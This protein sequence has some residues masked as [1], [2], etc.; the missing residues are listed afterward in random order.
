MLEVFGKGL[1]HGGV[2]SRVKAAG[3]RA[4]MADADGVAT[5]E[6]HNICGVKVFGSETGEDGGSIGEG[7]GQV[8]QCSISCGEAQSIPPSQWH[9]IVRTSRQVN[10]VTSSKSS[11]I[12]TRDD[13]STLLVDTRT[14][15][16]DDFES[17]QGQ[18]R[19]SIL[20][21]WSTR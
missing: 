17:S 16:I 6:S 12:S 19:R 1:I 14:Q 2:L 9:V 5:R 18:V 8:L 10:R 7:C 21:A 20:L 11:D 3:E 15:V 13:S 4:A